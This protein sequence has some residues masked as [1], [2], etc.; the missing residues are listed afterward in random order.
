MPGVQREPF[1]VLGSPHQALPQKPP[2]ARSTTQH[3]FTGGGPPGIAAEGGGSA[4]LCRL[5]SFG[6]R[7]ARVAGPPQV[8]ARGGHVWVPE[9][10]DQGTASDTLRLNIYQL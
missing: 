6:D 7:L 10:E 3:A 5:Y 1:D 8:T 2:S 9:R 4:Q